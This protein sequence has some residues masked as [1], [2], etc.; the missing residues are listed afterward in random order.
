MNY[1]HNKNEK[2]NTMTCAKMKNFM[3]LFKS[4]QIKVIEKCVFE[5]KNT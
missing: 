4:F 1:T 5:K 2:K 3:I